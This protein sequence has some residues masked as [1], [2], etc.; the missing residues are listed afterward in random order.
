MR[1]RFE[2]Q[3]EQLDEAT[4]RAKTIGGWLVLHVKTF[5][6]SGKNYSMSQSESMQ[7]VADR[8]HE[9]SILPPIE[10]EKPKQTVKASDFE[11]KS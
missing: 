11:P 8:D 4:W 2:W 3:W 1:K 7:F 6:V 9:W 10:P 5:T